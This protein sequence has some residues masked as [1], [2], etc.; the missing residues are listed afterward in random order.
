[1]FGRMQISK[2]CFCLF[3]IGIL[4][5][6]VRCVKEKAADYNPWSISLRWI[7]AYQDESWDHVRTGL[8]WSFSFLGATLPAGSFDASVTWKNDRLFTC[9]FSKLGF[10]KE[11]L[12]SLQ[13]IFDRLKASEE[14]SAKG[15][16]DL[17]RLLMLTIYSSNHYYRITG[18]HASY[19]TLNELHLSDSI[20][21]LALTHSAVASENRMINMPAAINSASLAF[22]SASEGTGSIADSSFATQIHETMELMPNGQLR[23]AIYD[24]QG[25][26]LPSANTLI[27]AAGKPGKCMW[28]HESKALTLFQEQDDVPGY[29]TAQE[30]MERVAL[31]NEE[32]T[33]IRN[34]LSTELV[35]A[36]Q[37]DHTQSELLYISF[38]EPSAY[39]IANDWDLTIDEATIVLADLPTHE[40]AEFP[41]LGLLYQREAVDLLAPYKT[42]RVPESVREHSFYEPDF[43]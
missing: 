43:F 42:E 16:I 39:R 8:L 3:I 32:L 28:C 33:E 26:L 14:Y 35:F 24:L 7:P 12:L 31:T 2:I 18:M 36:N 37:S 38:M 1:M 23:F 20:L 11:A 40:Y 22:Y 10:K 41:F 27:S 19:N 17:G 25:N 6:E 34:A 13:V 15:G 21:Q 5:T 30:F 4:L 29:L 9:D